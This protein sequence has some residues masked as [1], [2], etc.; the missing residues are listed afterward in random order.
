MKIVKSKKS[1]KETSNLKITNVN[2]FYE[3]NFK[4]TVGVVENENMICV[5]KEDTKSEYFIKEYFEIKK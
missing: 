2:V 1:I 5:T 4:I 3:N